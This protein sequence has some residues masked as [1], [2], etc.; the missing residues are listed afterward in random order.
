[1]P[2]I[3]NLDVELA[4]QK[5]KLTELSERVGISILPLERLR[6]VS[7]AH[8]GSA[9]M[10]LISGRNDLTAMRIPASRPPPP[11]GTTTVSISADCSRISKPTV[12]WPAMTATSL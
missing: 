6:A 4:K 10:T 11:T 2:I 9:A 7:S 12:P 1:M 5:M 8:S 3:I